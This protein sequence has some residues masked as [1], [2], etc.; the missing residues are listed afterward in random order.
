MLDL[1]AIQKQCQTSQTTLN[2]EAW[3][4]DVKIR[5]LTVAQSA[6]VVELSS[7]GQHVQAMVR[8][9]SFS[10][11]E[12]VISFQDLSELSGDAFEGIREINEALGKLN[13]PKK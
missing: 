11:V 3:K 9:V 13:E 10:L 5:Q 1:Q 6:E 7:K 2:V 12:P 8:G 4:G